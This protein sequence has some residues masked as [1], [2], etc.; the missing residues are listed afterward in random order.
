MK[1]IAVFFNEPNFLDDPF[2]E[3]E[4][5]IAYRQIGELFETRGGRFA[6]VRSPESYRGGNT[7]KGGWIFRDGEF[8]RTEDILT[9]AVIFNR[10]SFLG[11]GKAVVVNDPELETLCTDKAQTYALFPHLFPLTKTVHTKE[12]ATAFL[13]LIPTAMAVAKPID[14]E[15]G[16]GVFIL[17]KKQILKAIPS[18][19][20]LLQEFIDTSAGIPGITEAIHDFRIIGIRGKPVVAYV[21]MA[22]PGSYLANVARGA[23]MREVPLPTVPPEPMRIFEEVDAALQRFPDRL[24]SV[25][26]GRD[27]SGVWKIIELNTKPG[28]SVMEQDPGTRRYLTGIVELL[29]SVAEKSPYSHEPLAISHQSSS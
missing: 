13:R 29:L 23:T 24:Y 25:D 26:T 5:R 2:D 8:Q 11:D 18:Y 9:P 22:K 21:R 4:Y 12:E 28:T 14:E 16:R 27:R 10:G 15:A 19:P 1:L 3:E 17:P 20:Y 7:F 6:I